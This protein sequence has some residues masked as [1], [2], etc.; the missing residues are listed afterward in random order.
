[1]VVHG[2]G[3]VLV[4][5]SVLVCSL[6]LVRSLFLVLCSNVCFGGR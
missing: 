4:V 1:M 3:W 2:V 5:N 6:A